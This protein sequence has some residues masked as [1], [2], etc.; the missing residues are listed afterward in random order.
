[1]KKHTKVYLV[2]SLLLLLFASGFTLSIHHTDAAG[3]TK[4]KVHYIDTG[5]SDSILIESNKHYMLIDAGDVDDVDTVVGYLKKQ[6]VKT[7]DY[8][9]L[10]H[11]HADHIGAASSVIDIFIIKKIIMPSKTNNT[12][13]YET[14]LDTIA[15]NNLKITKP[16]VGKSYTLGKAS[17]TLL[18]PN[19]YE[20]GSNLN[21]YSISLRLVN[22]KNSFLFVGD[23]ET[24]ALSDIQKNKQTIASDVLLCGHHGSKTS[25]TAT[26]LKAVSPTYAVISVGKNSYGHPSSTTLSLLKKKK[27]TTYRTDENGTIIA[28]ST[29]TK[30]TFSAKPTDLSK[31]TSTN[32]SDDNS[33]KSN[34]VYITDTGKKYHKAGCRYLKSSKTKTTV[35]KA[36]KAG[37]EPCKVCKPAS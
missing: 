35:E 21:N 29:G 2:V 4:M 9:I 16:K 19:S 33:S 18:A 10:T 5:E 13:V 6:K 34:V 17:F 26:L 11:P 28:T 37:Y 31:G 27:I 20:Y 7:L 32:T 8:L 23:C 15:K 36:K 14:L 12:K 25:T 3:Y 30:I 22:G 1:M 24:E